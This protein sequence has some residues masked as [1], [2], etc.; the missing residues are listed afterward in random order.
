MAVIKVKPWGKD[1][2]DHVLINEEDFNPDIHEHFDAK[3]N[4]KDYSKLKVDEIKALLTE[5]GIPFD[6]A[7]KKD[8]LIKLIPAE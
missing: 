8:D 7:D 6:A 1:Q 3:P 2:G 4:G 5:K